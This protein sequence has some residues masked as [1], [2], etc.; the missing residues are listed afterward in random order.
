LAISTYLADVWS[1]TE[2]GD[3]ELSGYA[4]AQMRKDTQLGVQTMAGLSLVM[5]LC[6]AVFILAQGLSSLYL[7]SILLFGLLSLHVLISAAFLRDVRTLH[8]LGMTLLI[9]GALSLTILA[10]RSGE[11]H[12][13]VMAASVML[14]VAIPLVPWALRETIIVIGL[15]YVLLTSSLVA[16]PGRFT[17]DSLWALQL[18]VLG[19]AV[20]AVAI[21]TRNTFIRKQDLRAR[22]E[23]ENAHSDMELLSMQDHL[24]GA[25]N[26]RFLSEKFAEFAQ[27]CCAQKKALHVA[28]LDIDD[29]K[30]INDEFGHQFGDKILMSVADIFVRLLEGKGRLIRL[31]GDEFQIIYCGDGLDGLI[32][33]AIAKLQQE[34]TDAGLG[35]D[36]V[37]T[38]SAGIVTAEPGQP[39][40][41]ES[42]YKS[43]DSALYR[44]KH[45]RPASN[46]G[47]GALARTGTWRL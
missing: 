16:V 25:W 20:I 14:F 5:Q 31:G 1:A 33:T 18:L 41:L 40:D 27:N 21:T 3:P 35:S 43:A 29:F 47:V 36:R 2:F 32:E 9:I 11:L 28:I 37:I 8:V 42:L 15:T 23:L 6:V 7:T 19:A 17:T 24:T 34:F 12:I 4:E 38:L 22:F 13:G 45:N 30:G 44:E 39:A 10:H 26:R 46:G